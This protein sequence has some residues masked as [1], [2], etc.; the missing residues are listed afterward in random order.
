MDTL[1]MTTS[2]IAVIATDEYTPL[3]DRH[4]IGRICTLGITGSTGLVNSVNSIVSLLLSTDYCG[5]IEAV[6]RVWI[7]R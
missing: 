4:K 2:V 3:N 1:S 6:F 5:V 7:P